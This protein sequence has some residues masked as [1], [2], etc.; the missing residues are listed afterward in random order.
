[1]IIDSSEN[2]LSMSFKKVS[3]EIKTILGFYSWEHEQ[4]ITFSNHLG[5][6]SD[7]DLGSQYCWILYK[8]WFDFL[9]VAYFIWKV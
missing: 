2:S 1:M 4:F 8:M 5:G 6:C 7:K 9:K 3:I